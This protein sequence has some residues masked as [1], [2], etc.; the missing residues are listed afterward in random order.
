MSEKKAAQD[1]SALKAQFEVASKAIKS[2]EACADLIAY[3][4]EVPEPFSPE[5]SGENPW[6]A[7]DPPC[8]T[9]V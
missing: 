7:V 6:T 3:C 5:Y 2:S 8:C 1:L 4:K 9:L